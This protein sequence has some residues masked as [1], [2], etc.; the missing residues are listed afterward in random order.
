MPCFTHLLLGYLANKPTKSISFKT[1]LSQRSMIELTHLFSAF[2]GICLRC[3]NLNFF[4]LAS[5]PQLNYSFPSLSFGV[6]DTVSEIP[7]LRF[8]PSREGVSD[9]LVQVEAYLLD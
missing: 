9:A 1:S 6:V 4:V 5:Y 8:G 7:V 2:P 3:I